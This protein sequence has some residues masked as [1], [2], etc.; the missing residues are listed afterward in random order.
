MTYQVQLHEER[1]AVDRF[2]GP[3]RRLR[4]LPNR[5]RDCGIRED[6]D[7]SRPKVEVVMRVVIVIIEVILISVVLITVNDGRVHPA[8]ARR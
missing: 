7:I 1:V 2:G 6:M 5:Q 8:A 3:N 4:F